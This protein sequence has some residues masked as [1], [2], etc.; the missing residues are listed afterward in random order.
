[1]CDDRLKDKT[2]SLTHR[3]GC[4]N[5][6]AVVVDMSED[7]HFLDASALL[8]LVW[9]VSYMQFQATSVFPLGQEETYVIAYTAGIRYKAFQK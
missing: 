8:S 9:H 5:N 4:L 2:H 6:E 1:M 7:D 3:T